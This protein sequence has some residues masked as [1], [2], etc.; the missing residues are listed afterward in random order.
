MPPYLS[1]LIMQ[2]KTMKCYFFCSKVAFVT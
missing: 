1:F 2:K